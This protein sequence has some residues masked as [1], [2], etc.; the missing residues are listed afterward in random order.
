MNIKSAWKRIIVENMTVT[1]N[2]NKKHIFKKMPRNIGPKHPKKSEGTLLIHVYQKKYE[3]KSAW[4]KLY[5][6]VENKAIQI[7]SVYDNMI[8]F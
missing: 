5:F 1:Y 7:V 4:K 3:K 6:I 8:S 2:W